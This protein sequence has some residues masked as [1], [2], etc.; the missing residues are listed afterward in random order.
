MEL[1]AEPLILLVADYFADAAERGAVR[2][3]IAPERI[4]VGFLSSMFT[5]FMGDPPAEGEENEHANL[6][7]DIFVRGVTP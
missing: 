5:I 7:I 1:A 6:I 2:R 4:A 3:D